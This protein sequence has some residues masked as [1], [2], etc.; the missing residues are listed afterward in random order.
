MPSHQ[1]ISFA[2]ILIRY[3]HVEERDFYYTKEKPK[4]LLRLKNIS[5][6]RVNMKLAWFVQTAVGKTGHGIIVNLEPEVETVEPIGDR[7][8]AIPGWGLVGVLTVDP[9]LP[10]ERPEEIPLNYPS[11]HTLYT[12]QIFDEDVHRIEEKRHKKI[13]GLSLAMVILA[14]IAAVA[15]II[16]LLGIALGWW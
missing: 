10:P 12:F 8:L 2:V 3:D 6:Q 15:G 1:V 13:H 14:G 16:S 9:P 4:F 5:D 11:F 7:L